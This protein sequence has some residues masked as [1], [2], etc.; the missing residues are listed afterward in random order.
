MVVADR[1][2]LLREGLIE[3]I[4]TPVDIYENPSSVFGADFI[5]LANIHLGNVTQLGDVTRVQ[6]SDQIH[7]DCKHGQFAAGQ[8][9]DVMSRP[10]QV[11]VSAVPIQ[12]QNVWQGQVSH[13]FFLG[14]VAD[15]YV[16]VGDIKIRSQLSPPKYLDNGQ[17]VWIHIPPEALRLYAHPI[18][19]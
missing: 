17:T 16:N 2:V 7:I 4:S 5:G 9:V 8:A 13:T 11:V 3:Q 1:I 15:V 6:L 12:G 18:S 10:E 19:T 14:N